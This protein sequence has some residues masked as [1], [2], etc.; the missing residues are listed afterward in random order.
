MILSPS[1]LKTFVQCP[2][3][4]KQT[5]I[6]KELKYTQSDAAKRGEQLHSLMETACLYGWDNVKWTDKKS[7]VY[8]KNFVDTVWT[9]KRQGWNIKTEYGIGTDGY[10]AVDF[11]DK[12]ETNKIRC[13]VDLFAFKPECNLGVVLD[14]KTGKKYESDKLQLQVN[15]V[16]LKAATGITNFNIGFMYLD[17]GDY[18]YEQIDVSEFNIN[19]TDPL[20]FATS[21]CLEFLEAYTDTLHAIEINKFIQTPNRFCKWC[22]S[23][24]CPHR[25]K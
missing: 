17:S 2:Y 22:D 19:D 24:D 25:N 10:K 4:F 18:T 5:Y 8:A 9:M 21:P 20:S 7:E 11:W 6:T 23:P 3:K 13:R 12:S 15:A 16:C 1:A 14:W